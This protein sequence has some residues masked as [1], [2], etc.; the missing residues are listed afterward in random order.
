MILATAGVVLGS[1]LPTRAMTMTGESPTLTV[2]P[3]RQELIMDPGQSY[4]LSFSVTNA[5]G[6]SATFTPVAGPYY[7]TESG[8]LDYATENDRTQMYNWISFSESS[9]TLEPGA[10]T[11]VDF[12]ITVPS[13]A[14]GGGQYAA[15]YA[16]VSGSNNGLT[17]VSRIGCLLVGRINGDVVES[18]ELLSQTL[19][20]VVLNGNFTASV[21]VRTTGNINFTVTSQLKV[22]DILS[23]NVLYDSA[24]SGSDQQQVYPEM[25]RTFVYDWGGL[26]DIGIFDVEYI[27]TFAGQTHAAHKLVWAVPLWLLLLVIGMLAFLVIFGW[28]AFFSKW[29]ERRKKRKAA[30]ASQTDKAS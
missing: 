19:P 1:A 14:P 24:S 18:G 8:S 3:T 26:P 29:W 23:G 30:K 13:D 11:E 7:P 10:T 4:D 16:E 2:S 5:G 21:S 22:K 6:E 25:T 20:T 12:T 28:L 9:F 17:S 15:V 27:V